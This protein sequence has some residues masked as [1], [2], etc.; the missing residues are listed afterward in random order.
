MKRERLTPSPLARSM[1]GV[2]WYEVS[3][4]SIWIK[5]MSQAKPVRVSRAA[6]H[7][8]GPQYGAFVL[9]DAARAAIRA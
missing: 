4:R 9:A 3:A 1:S 7:G 5:L 6:V 2:D 8:Q